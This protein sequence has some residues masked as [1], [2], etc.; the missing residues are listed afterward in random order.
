VEEADPKDQDH[1]AAQ[2]FIAPPAGQAQEV[3]LR[4]DTPQKQCT[5]IQDMSRRAECRFTN[6]EFHVNEDEY[7]LYLHL[8]YLLILLH[9]SYYAYSPLALSY[10]DSLYIHVSG[11]VP[12]VWRFLRNSLFHFLFVCLAF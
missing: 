2:V 7:M 9:F 11:G 12:H 3:P 8:R 6:D 10:H 1:T 5:K 4:N